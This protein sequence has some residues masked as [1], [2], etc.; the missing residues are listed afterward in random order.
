MF[1]FTQEPSSGSRD[2]YSAKITNLVQ[3]YVW[4]QTSLLWLHIV[5]CCECLRF[6][7]QRDYLIL[8]SRQKLEIAPPHIL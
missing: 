3:L 8:R 1:R 2:Q 7:V 5:T 4:V 6:T